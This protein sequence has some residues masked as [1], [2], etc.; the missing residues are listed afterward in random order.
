MVEYLP[1]HPKVQGSSTA[2]NAGTREERLSAGVSILVEYSPRHLKVK[3]LSLATN[4][5][6]G[7]EK[8]VKK[9]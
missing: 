7:K 8:M 3:G 5:G 4:A 9:L 2:T 6:T 1:H